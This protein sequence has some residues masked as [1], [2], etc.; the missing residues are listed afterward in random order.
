LQHP[1]CVETKLYKD[2]LLN[3]DEIIMTNSVRKEV[4]VL[5][6]KGISKNSTKGNY[7]IK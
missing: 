2:N 7:V 3:A 4:K 5:Y 1:G 6:I